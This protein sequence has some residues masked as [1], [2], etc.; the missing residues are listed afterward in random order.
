MTQ[1]H[2]EHN[3]AELRRLI[4]SAT[5]PR[6]AAPSGAKGSDE[7][8]LRAAWLALG[9][10]IEQA[11]MAP[12]EVPAALKELAS[13]TPEE[14]PRPR[15]LEPAAEPASAHSGR[16]EAA[17]S[18]ARWRRLQWAFS[19][20]LV[21]VAVLWAA[22]RWYQPAPKGPQGA[23][24][25]IAATE[26]PQSQH[27]QSGAAG[28]T[29]VARSSHSSQASSTPTAV[30]PTTPDSGAKQPVA[31]EPSRA[32]ATTASEPVEP[33]ASADHPAESVDQL[34]WDDQLDE[35][36]AAA[37]EATAQIE[38]GALAQSS[39]LADRLDQLRWDLE[40]TNF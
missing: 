33:I 30:E 1:S 8:Q 11:G 13:R 25:E 3:D 28:G 32:V 7:E 29:S 20:A 9:T 4:E 37:A 21:L 39:V 2:N 36:I 31:G 23:P 12:G 18:S 22:T 10:L 15:S 16:R 26:N 34:A 40:G 6:S 38:Y 27:P 19:A 17:S 24:A 5:A 14:L 35:M